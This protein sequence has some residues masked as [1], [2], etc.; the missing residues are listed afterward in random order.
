MGRQIAVSPMSLQHTLKSSIGCTG[1]GL[2]SGSRV[3]LTLTPAPTDTGIVFLRTDVGAER[4]LVA[5]L[6]DKVA[7]TRLCTLIG[8]AEGTL[9]GTVEHLM[10]ALRGSG[11]DNAV[12]ELDGPEVPIMDGSSEPFVFLIECAGVVAQ[13]APRRSLRVLKEVTVVDGEKRVS[14]LPAPQSSFHAEIEFSSAAIRRQE[15]VLRLPTDAERSGTFKAEVARARTFGF[16]HEVD[17]LRAAGLARGG[18]LDNAVVIDG[19]RVMNEGGLRM[20]DEFVRHKLLDAVGD[21]YL[22]GA[23]IRGHFHG[24][25]PGHEMNNRLLR[26]LF[27]DRANYT[28]EVGETARG[29]DEPRVAAIA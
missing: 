28:W 25:R 17:M 24:V 23:P 8:N 13:D 5:A 11:I 26:G 15:G 2:H 9:V 16:R 22:A 3:R 29:W 20:P 4:A 19:D 21:L 10:A 7:D 27:A 1:I 12:V 14:L 6:W 18:S